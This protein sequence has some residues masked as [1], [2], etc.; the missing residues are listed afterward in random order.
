MNNNKNNSLN[1]TTDRYEVRIEDLTFDFAKKIVFLRK[2]LVSSPTEKEL[3]ISKQ[4]LRSGTSIAANVA[5][6][7][8]P[9]SDADYLSKINIALKEA[10]ETKFWLRL[11][12]ECNYIMDSEYETLIYDC[13]KII[14]I[15]VTIVKKSKKK[16]KIKHT[17]LKNFSSS[18]V[19]LFS[20]F[21]NL[22]GIDI[23][24][25]VFNHQEVHSLRE[26]LYIDSVAI[27][28]TDTLT[29]H[30]IQLN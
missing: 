8:H 20:D 30:V 1:R 6:A 2:D 13:N 14:S 11:L 16:T 9:Q 28:S 18:Q 19:L 27:E 23:S 26:T 21:N 25:K 22:V 12:K 4:I 15:L 17:K 29:L 5:E 24:L 7:E 10:N 3:I